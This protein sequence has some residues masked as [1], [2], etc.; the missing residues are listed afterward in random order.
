MDSE[1]RYG[2]Y[3][4]RALSDRSLTVGLVIDIVITI[5]IFVSTESVFYTL[6]FVAYCRIIYV[7]DCHKNR[8][9]EILNKLDQL[10]ENRDKVE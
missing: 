3:I 8:Q 1:D 6:M 9:L 5:L 2:K 10:L 7:F 4:N